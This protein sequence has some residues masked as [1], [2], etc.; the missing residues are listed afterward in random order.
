MTRT[1]HRQLPHSCARPPRD[2]PM[3]SPCLAWPTLHSHSQ[4]STR[5]QA[6]PLAIA[7]CGATPNT[8]IPGTSRMQMNWD[9]S[10]KGSAPAPLTQPNPAWQ[11]QT[12]S[13]PS[14]MT[15]YCMKG[16]TRSRTPKLSAK[17]AHRRKTLIEPASQLGETESSTLVIAEPKRARWNWSRS[18]STASS[19]ARQQSLPAS[20]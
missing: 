2:P 15:T 9:G 20:T 11:A 18:S 7:N 4:S 10:A 12:H 16:D 19:P 6:T 3:P 13:N 1:T 8:K 14:P 5:K 17:Y